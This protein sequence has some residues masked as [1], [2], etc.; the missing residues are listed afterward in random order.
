MYIWNQPMISRTTEYAI[1]AAL[2]L[3]GRAAGAVSAREIARETRV[4]A[5]YLAKILQSLGRAGI[6]R[7]QPGP[8]GGF[9]LARPPE[10]VHV[11]DVMDAIRPL[12]PIENCPLGLAEHAE[13]LCPY[14]ARLNQAMEAV[15]SVFSGCTLAELLQESGDRT[16]LCPARES[17]VG[18]T[19]S[20]STAS[21]AA[22]SSAAGA[23]QPSSN[24][25]GTG[26]INS[27][28]GRDP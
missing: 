24:G 21:R 17:P 14:H 15:Q 6:V 28:K 10:Q 19:G 27:K 12:R 23:V 18:S 5:G 4:P 20:S 9:C 2:W 16:A 13:R 11:V 7:A 22:D 25:S 1:R 8:G 26:P 3:A